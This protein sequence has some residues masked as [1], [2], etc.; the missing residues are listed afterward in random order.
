MPVRTVREKLIAGL[1]RLGYREEENPNTT[2]YVVFMDRTG[3][4]RFFV[5]RS[6][7]LRKGL[8]LSSSWSVGDQRR[9]EILAAGKDQVKG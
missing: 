7:A 4:D 3:T 9:K 6:G 2:R 8:N 1:T 5:G